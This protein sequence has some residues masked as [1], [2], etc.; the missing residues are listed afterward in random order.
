METKKVT[1]NPT[2]LDQNTQ[3]NPEHYKNATTLTPSIYYFPSGGSK[4]CQ[5]VCFIIEDSI[6]YLKFSPRF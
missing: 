5:S 2:F 6:N 4:F 3:N 1:L